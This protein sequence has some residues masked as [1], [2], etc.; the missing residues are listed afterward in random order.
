MAR[1]KFESAYARTVSEGTST[2]ASSERVDAYVQRIKDE[3]DKLQ[4]AVVEAGDNE[5]AVSHA[6]GFV[7]EEWSAATHRI[8]AVVH[9]QDPTA[10]ALHETVDHGADIAFGPGRLGPVQVKFYGDPDATAH[11]VADPGYGSMERLIPADQ[12]PEVRARLLELADFHD[13]SAPLIA[14]NYRAAAAL[15]TDHLDFAD[16]Q[17]APLTRA[18][19]EGLV[20]DARD[21]H[22][23]NLDELGL[24]PDQLLDLSVGLDQALAAGA[25]AAAVS[26]GLQLAAVVGDAIKR[27]LDRGTLTLDDLAELTAGRGGAVSKSAAAGTIAGALTLAAQSGAL[28]DAAELVAPEAISAVVVLS[29]N[30]AIASY[31]AAVGQTTWNEAGYRMTKMGAVLA[32]GYA[33]AAMASTI[34]VPVVAQAVGFFI[35]ATAVRVSIVGFEKVALEDA[36]ET[37]RTYWGLIDQDYSIPEAVLIRQGLKTGRLKAAPLKGVGLKTTDVKSV[38]L[39]PADVKSAPR[40]LSRK[41]VGPRKVGYG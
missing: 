14:E 33:G 40:Y 29:I 7:A 15:V 27:A 31:Q 36:V 37:G 38:D 8:D 20:H 25:D 32:G 18:E 26:L 5:Q 22:A 41:A 23:L 34:P 35:G 21:D 6:Q 10:E 39:K 28:G 13:G 11:A 3:I 30:A 9:G 24:T 4:S 17:S 12:L 1:D 19:S 16:A 2:T